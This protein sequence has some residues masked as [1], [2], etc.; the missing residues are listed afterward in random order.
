MSKKAIMIEVS[1][2]MAEMLKKCRFKECIF[3]NC[4]IKVIKAH[5]I[6]KNKIL[7]NISYNGMI[8]TFDPRKSF[9]TGNFEEIGIN[10]ASTFFGF[11]NHHDTTIFSSI[12]NF[13]YSNTLEQGFLFA[14]RAC[15]W[16]YVAKRV[17]LCLDKELVER[18]KN[19][20][21]MNKYVAGQQDLRD[22]VADLDEFHIELF[23]SRQD[24]NY[25][26][27][28]TKVYQLPYETLIA[29]NSAF[30]IYSDLSGK[31]INDPI[32]YEDKINALYLNIFPQNN[33]TF[34]LLSCF[35]DD[36]NI[37]KN[38]FS[39]IDSF[40]DSQLEN[41]FSQ[42][43][44]VHCENSFLSPERW[45]KVPSQKRKKTVSIFQETLFGPDDPNYLTATAPIN[46]F[47]SLR[48]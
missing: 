27:L 4:P 44:I 48:K 14:Y 20:I 9:V 21:F 34:I 13:D 17:S 15:A 7:N 40:T 12:E 10:T 5:S 38:L 1:K 42:L 45:K 8:T 35:T 46:L 25:N 39:H 2:N 30:S 23:K 6:Q 37:F 22:I 19:P 28:T 43:I 26:I 24:R 47:K 41:I 18:T 11:C 16:E 33:K 31:I 29:V 32:N 3:P 36:L